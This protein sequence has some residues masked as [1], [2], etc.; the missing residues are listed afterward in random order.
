MVWGIGKS[1]YT[2]GVETLVLPQGCALAPFAIACEWVIQEPY[3]YDIPPHGPTNATPTRRTTVHHG[4][5]RLTTRPLVPAVLASPYI[6]I[7][8]QLGMRE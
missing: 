5:I 8:R 2:S 7:I 4:D 1:T 3:A 6:G